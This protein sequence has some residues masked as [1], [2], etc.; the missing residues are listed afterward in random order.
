MTVANLNEKVSIGPQIRK[1]LRDEQSDGILVGKQKMVWNDFRL[2]A[3]EL[4]RNK[5][6]D[7]CSK[8]V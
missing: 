5:K 1:L 4:T 3:T 7:F 2:V 8:P 6:A